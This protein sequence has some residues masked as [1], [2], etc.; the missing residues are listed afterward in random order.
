MTKTT[1][2]TRIL[3]GKKPVANPLQP[4]SCPNIVH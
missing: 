1:I 2:Q 3:K 4:A